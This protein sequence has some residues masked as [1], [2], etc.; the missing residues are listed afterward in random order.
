MCQ[1]LINFGYYLH[2]N[3]LIGMKYIKNV[4]FLLFFFCFAVQSKA[5]SGN[6]DSTKWAKEGT[7]KIIIVPG[8]TEGN[9]LPVTTLPCEVLC[10]IEGMRKNDRTVD[11]NYNNCTVIRIYP[12]K[13]K[14]IDKTEK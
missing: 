7:Y 12:R 13:Q 9:V 14:E 11:F 1:F 8:T 2:F 3:S 5:Q 4:S 6:C 10:Q